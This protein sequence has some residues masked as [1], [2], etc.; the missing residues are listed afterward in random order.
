MDFFVLHISLLRNAI[1]AERGFEQAVVLVVDAA[2]QHTYKPDVPWLWLVSRHA[3]GC[4]A[5]KR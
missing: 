3:G 5:L 2:S 1:T 4:T